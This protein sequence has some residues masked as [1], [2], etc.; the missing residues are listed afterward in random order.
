MN[1]VWLISV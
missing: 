1:Q